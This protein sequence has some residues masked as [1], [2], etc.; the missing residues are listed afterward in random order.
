MQI[1]L[2]SIVEYSLQKCQKQIKSDAAIQQKSYTQNL[3]FTQFSFVSCRIPSSCCSTIVF[4][5]NIFKKMCSEKLKPWRVLYTRSRFEKT[6][7]T[8]LQEQG[9][10]VYL[11]L[12][13]QL[14]QW[15]DRKHWVETPLFPNYI[16][17]R[18][19]DSVLFDLLKTK[20]VVKA[21]YHARKPVLVRES[22]MENIIRLIKF[23]EQIEVEYDAM[24][25]GSKVSITSGPLKGIKGT[26]VERK[27]KNKFSFEVEAIKAAILIEVDVKHLRKSKES[28]TNF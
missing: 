18:A 25:P 24:S 1:F 28:R 15:S 23:S 6:V 7:A 14:H 16:F 21:V 4:L 3:H 5:P 26:L 17:L 2:Q 12:V 11:P 9:V 10:E 13:R 19:E 20:G 22:Q 8:T 27:G